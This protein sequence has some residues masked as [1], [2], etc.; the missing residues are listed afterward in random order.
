MWPA[1]GK[2]IFSA[3]DRNQS[4]NALVRTLEG[5]NQQRP[6]EVGQ[7]DPFKRYKKNTGRCCFVKNGAVVMIVTIKLLVQC[8]GC[9]MLFF[10]KKSQLNNGPFLD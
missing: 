1:G 3:F 2:L 8:F 7:L 5:A 9:F 10:L 4:V 6:G